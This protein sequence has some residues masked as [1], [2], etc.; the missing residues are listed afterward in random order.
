VISWSIYILPMFFTRRKELPASYIKYLKTTILLFILEGLLRI[1]LF[2][3]FG[4]HSL[5]T[6]MTFFGVLWDVSF[7]V[8]FIL[9]MK[10]SQRVR[11]TFVFTYPAFI[12]R[13]HLIQH[14]NHLITKKFSKIEDVSEPLPSPSKPDQPEETDERE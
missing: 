12:W 5:L 3:K 2:Y 8:I 1:L 10:R 4:L 11:E 7:S 14:T 6:W 13:T 9:Y